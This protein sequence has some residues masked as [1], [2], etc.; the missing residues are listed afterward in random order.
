MTTEKRET[1][2]TR[3]PKPRI[4]WSDKVGDWLVVTRVVSD[5][6]WYYLRAATLAKLGIVATVP[7]SKM[8]CA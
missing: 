5:T 7:L 2:H 6:Q 8:E 4:V 1:Y 3:P